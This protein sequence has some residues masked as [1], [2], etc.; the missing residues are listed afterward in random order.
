MGNVVLIR[1]D[2]VHFNLNKSECFSDWLNT[3]RRLPL[4]KKSRYREGGGALHERSG[5][6]GAVHERE[7]QMSR[8]SK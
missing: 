8:S 3:K 4:R 6:V 7:Q 2:W 5:D 1:V